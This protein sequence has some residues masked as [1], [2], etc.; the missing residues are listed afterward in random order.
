MKKQSAAGL[1]FSMF[2]RAVVVIIGI[3]IIV[4]GIVTLMKFIKIETGNN[5]GPATTVGDS[6][7]T[8]S[9]SRDDLLANPET[10]TASTYVPVDG[11]AV[12]PAYHKNILV[13][14]STSISGLAGRWCTRLNDAGY[15][16]T[17]ASDYQTE[18]T[19]TRIV[20]KE[21]GVGQE[22]VSYFNGASYEVG[23]ITEGTSEDTSKYDVVIILGTQD[24]DQ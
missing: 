4:L 1:F 15:V 7:L 20:A 17:F 23:T 14:N 19:T 18:Q 13:L 11:E 6:I 24:N 5:E 21:A 12:D 8:E 3:V 2:L 9:E 16:N 10:S 22:L